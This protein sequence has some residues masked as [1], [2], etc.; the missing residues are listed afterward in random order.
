MNKK[1]ST[2]TRMQKLAKASIRFDA[3]GRKII[4]Y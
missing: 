2:T 3:I 4:F 1:L